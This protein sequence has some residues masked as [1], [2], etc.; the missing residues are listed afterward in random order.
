M[1]GNI[2][3]PWKSFKKD[4]PYDAYEDDRNGLETDFVQAWFIYKR[5]YSPYLNDRL[6]VSY[7]ACRFTN[8]VFETYESHMKTSPY[9]IDRI[10]VLA[11]VESEFVKELILKDFLQSIVM[12]QSYL[13]CQ[14]ACHQM[15]SVSVCGDCVG[16][17]YT[18]KQL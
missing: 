15:Q 9:P 8:G 13:F 5:L 12:D 4:P 1:L 6:F 14:C 2:K 16:R 11:W 7:K 17:H 10:E 3:L 18:P